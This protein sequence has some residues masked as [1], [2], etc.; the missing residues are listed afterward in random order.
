MPSLHQNNTTVSLKANDSDCTAPSWF[1]GLYQNI[2]A[3]LD[4]VVDR[5]DNIVKTQHKHEEAI[6]QNARDIE[7]LSQRLSASEHAFASLQERNATTKEN[8]NHGSRAC[9]YCYGGLS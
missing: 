2:I 9:F 6:A 4:R 7:E 3:H 5:L 1:L 8:F